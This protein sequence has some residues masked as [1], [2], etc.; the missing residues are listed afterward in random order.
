MSRVKR[1][2]KRAVGF[3]VVNIIGTTSQFNARRRG[4]RFSAAKAAEARAMGINPTGKSWSPQLNQWIDG[5]D[6]VKRICRANGYGCEGSVNVKF[7]PPEEPDPGPYRVADDLV[8]QEVDERLMDEGV[9][10]LPG[11][12]YDDLTEKVREEITPVMEVD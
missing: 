9:T 11:R 12:E 10:E 3:P 5:P 4:E 1:T 6:D 7:N 8:E 2:P